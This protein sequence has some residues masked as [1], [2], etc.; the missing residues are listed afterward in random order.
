MGGGAASS[1]KTDAGR[2]PLKRQ[3][4]VEPVCHPFAD[5]P[6]SCS[7]VITEVNC[8]LTVPRS[9]PMNGRFYPE[10]LVPT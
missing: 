6:A 4:I 5:S 8:F 1:T 9:A 3:E 2:R 7:S 10:P